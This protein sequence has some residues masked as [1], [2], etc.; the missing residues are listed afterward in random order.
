VLVG[1]VVDVVDVVVGEEDMRGLRAVYG[2]LVMWDTLSTAGISLTSLH[3][4]TGGMW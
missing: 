1:V 2:W 4:A 3:H